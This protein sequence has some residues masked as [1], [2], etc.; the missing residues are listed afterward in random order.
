M[1]ELKEKALEAYDLGKELLKKD[2]LTS[3]DI[4]SLLSLGISTVTHMLLVIANNLGKSRA[5]HIRTQVI[6][7]IIEDS[8]LLDSEGGEVIGKNSCDC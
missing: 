6:A 5:K 4:D 7:S 8:Y 2:L 1:E 3:K